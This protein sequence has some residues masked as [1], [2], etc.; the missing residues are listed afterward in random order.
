MNLQR[1]TEHLISLQFSQFAVLKRVNQ[2]HRE[3][4]QGQT[5]DRKSNTRGTRPLTPLLWTAGA[6]LSDAAA[7]AV[8]Q[9]CCIRLQA[10]GAAGAPGKA[11]LRP[12]VLRPLVRQH[13]FC[14]V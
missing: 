9:G 7:R 3:R 12:L 10:Q 8:G 14:R 11:G 2:L 5:P 6:P 1:R 13:N 4:G